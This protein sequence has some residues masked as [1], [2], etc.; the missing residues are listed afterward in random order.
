[1]AQ[2]EMIHG[3]RGPRSERLDSM[4]A[5]AEA[6]AQAPVG[7]EARGTAY[8]SAH[9]SYRTQITSP[10]DIIDPY[11]GRRQV[12]KPVVAQ[13]RD[14]YFVND[15]KDLATRKLVD[16]ALQS[17]SR[18]GMA[19]DFWKVEDQRKAATDKKVADARATLR[20]LPREVVLDFIAGLETGTAEDHEL[21]A[22]AK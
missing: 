3:P 20:S 6:R 12:G 11:T 19:L 2:V 4:R 1:M 22:R 17:N 9:K 21:P 14:W 13:F 18:Y 5:S 10:A 16:E 15:V 7:I 8:A